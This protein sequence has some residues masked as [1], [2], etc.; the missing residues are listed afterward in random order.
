MRLPA[1][2]ALNSLR[3]MQARSCWLDYG[4]SG[5]ETVDD[6]YD[7]DDE[8]YVNESAT[9]VHYKK[10]ENPQDQQNHRNRPKH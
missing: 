2:R 1:S 8:K 9:N 6:N 3:V 7:R 4:A 10:S 5:D